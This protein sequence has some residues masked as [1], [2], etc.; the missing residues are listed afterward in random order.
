MT[1][2]TTTTTTAPGFTCGN[3]GGPCGTCGPGTCVGLCPENGSGV[4][5]SNYSSI[6][7]TG[8]QE[9]APGEVCVSVRLGTDYCGGACVMP[10][11]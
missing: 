11:P 8:N 1:E 10:C 4:C 3:P 7:C 9:C 2:S 5:A 6:G